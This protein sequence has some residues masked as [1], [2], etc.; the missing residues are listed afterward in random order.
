MDSLKTLMDK[1]AY[2]LV[3][4]LTENSVDSISLFY[5]ISALLALGEPLKCLDIINAHRRTLE[6]K[7]SILI[8]IHIEILCL[9]GRFDEAYEVLRYYQ[10]LP[11]DSQETEEILR[12]MP[13]YIRSE[14]K[15]TYQQH[16]ANEDELRA[17]LLSKDDEEVIVALNE[18]RSFPLESFLLPI[19]KIIRSHARQ[20]VRVFALLLLVDKKYDKEVEFLH[21]GELIKV[22]PAELHDPF[23]LEGFKD[24]QELTFALQSEYHDPSIA[25]NALQLISSYLLYIYPSKLDL[26]SDEIIAVFGY[27]SQKFLQ[28][29]GA[30]LSL[31]CEKK[32]L[33]FDKLNDLA[34][35]IEKALKTF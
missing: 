20:I 14:E 19:I 5:R 6:E 33:D 29:D 31:L 15:K 28:S 10:E 8:K 2:D 25:E 30:S 24:M 22:V 1:K 18:I 26:N 34:V 23:C 11:Y 9:L 17:K 32:N 13:A 27:L 12:A 16:V 3:L 4:K 7:P 21:F 35:K